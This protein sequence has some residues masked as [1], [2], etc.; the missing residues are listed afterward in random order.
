[1]AI[2]GALSISTCYCETFSSFLAVR[3]LFGI[4]MGGIWGPAAAIGLGEYYLRIYSRC[5]IKISKL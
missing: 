2:V 1:M 3:S 4:A 5:Q